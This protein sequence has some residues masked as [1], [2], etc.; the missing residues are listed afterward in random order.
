MTNDLLKHRAQQ[1]FSHA[2][3]YVQQAAGG[4][5][6]LNTSELAHLNQ[7]LTGGQDDPWR[8]S[9][10]SV[11][12]PSGKT[13]HFNLLNNP[14]VCARDVI[15]EAQK[16]AGNGDLPEAAFYLYS[17]IVLNHLF[18]DANRRTAAL[19][20]LWMVQAA[21]GSIDAA[22]LDKQPIGDLRD[23][24]DLANLKTK[25]KSLVAHT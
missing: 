3:N 6:I 15:G 1:K 14:I 18:L 2:L 20:T 8:L 11:T 24:K 16:L 4:P 21:G 22:L 10:V 5:K 12:I 9:P 17:Q 25:I 19:A 23:A 7:M 13:H